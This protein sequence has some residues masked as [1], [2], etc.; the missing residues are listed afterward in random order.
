[1][2]PRSDGRWGGTITLEDGSRQTVYGRNPDVV[3]AKI[4]QL[5]EARENGLLLASANAKTGD[6]LTQWLEDTAR[7]SIRPR[8]YECYELN[9]RRLLPLIGFIR[10][11]SLS[12]AHIQS[13]YGKL[14]KGSLAARSVR[15]AHVVLH[16]ALRQ[17]MHWGMIPRNPA[18]AVSLPRPERRELRVLNEDQLRH[19]IQGTQGERLHPLWVLLATT[20]LRLGEALGLKW[21][22]L[23]PK[24]GRLTVQ[25]A[26][27]RQRG[28][29]LVF[30]E[31][32][33][34]KSRRTVHLAPSTIRTLI[35]HRQRQ[36]EERLSKGPAWWDFNLIFC[37]EEGR[38]FESGQVSWRFH[39]AL[40]RIGLPQ[41]RLHD[42]RHTAATQLLTRGVHPKVVQELLGHSTITLT[43]DTYSHVSPALHA[44]VAQQM[45]S[46][47]SIPEGSVLPS[48]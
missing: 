19:L 43:L 47:F 18:D 1:M 20:G 15:Q 3:Q 45:E 24:S 6:F 16:R 36:I 25:R 26:L 33:T 30:T 10:L 27:Q 46:L 11:G 38:P 31:P 14:L 39:K 32:K 28:A 42:L 4:Q 9:V 13:A 23:D 22:D 5:R 21:D 17:A 2:Y 8:T 35:E 12:P 41:M 37:T 40:T 48:A 29:G 7:P 44:Q 34:G